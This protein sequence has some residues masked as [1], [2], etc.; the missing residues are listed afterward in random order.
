VAKWI[1]PTVGLAERNVIARIKG[2]PRVTVGLIENRGQIGIEKRYRERM[3]WT[4]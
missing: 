1:E 3:S 2:G 4:C